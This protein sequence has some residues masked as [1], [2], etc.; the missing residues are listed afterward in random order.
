MDKQQQK[1]GLQEAVCFED[2]FNS[3]F[4]FFRDE[5]LPPLTIIDAAS[6]MGGLSDESVV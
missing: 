5:S 3:A 1:A 6:I 2:K 4:I